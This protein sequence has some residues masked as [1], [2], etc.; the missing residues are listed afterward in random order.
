MTASLANALRLA[1]GLEV[2]PAYRSPYAE[3]LKELRELAT[4]AAEQT[5][6]VLGLTEQARLRGIVG[7]AE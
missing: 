4:A 2:V 3:L 7:G 5:A 6:L 1:E